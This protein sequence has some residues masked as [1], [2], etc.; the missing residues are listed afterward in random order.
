MDDSTQQLIFWAALAVLF[1]VAEMATVAFVALYVSV[2][3]VAGAAVAAF[4]GDVVWQVAAFVIT[5][6]VLLLLT[7]PLLTRKLQ[8]TEIPSNVNAIVGKR[9]IVT[10]EVDNDSGTGQI[11][12]GTEHWTARLADGEAGKVAPET[13]V[14][15][16]SVEGV[17]AYVRPIE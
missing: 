3:A 13:K 1:A 10:I 9:G 15:I 7:R 14:E 17:T 5:G 6:V 16:V 8:K 11:R 4:D 12:I 2:G